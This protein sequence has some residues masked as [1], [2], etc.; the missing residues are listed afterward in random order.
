MQAAQ[1]HLLEAARKAENEALNEARTAVLKRYRRVTLKHAQAAL[2]AALSL[3]RAK[4][5]AAV[6]EVLTL[7][8]DASRQI[9]PPPPELLG[10]LRRAV[11]DRVLNSNDIAEL[12]T[13]AKLAQD[14]R[15]L[16][17]RAVDRQRA[18]MNRY[19][20]KLPKAFRD[21]TAKTVREAIRK[22]LTVEQT[23]KLLEE[24]LNVSRNRAVLVATDQVRTA[25]SRADIMLLKASGAKE[26]Q[27]FS[28]R[29]PTAR[30]NHLALHGRVF[31]WRK[32]PELPGA[33]I[34]CECRALPV[35]PDSPE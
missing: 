28:Q 24:R 19:W 21:D 12:V 23:A 32:A 10:I 35:S 27:W 20:A 2:E 11:H 30:K 25:R 8:G 18:D 29:K 34:N 1:R 7:I 26:F 6:R 16:E 31:T 3:P 14:T 5:P 15:E 22:G 17:A 13:G 4:R 33:A 9:G